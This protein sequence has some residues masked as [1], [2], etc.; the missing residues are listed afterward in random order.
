M[1]PALAD[2]IRG[3]VQMMFT[4]IPESIEYVRAG[5]LR[6]L[7][8]TTTR[9]LEMLEDIPA[10][11]EFLPGFEATS[12]LGVCAPKGTPT[13]IID[14]I[15]GEINAVLADPKIKAQLVTWGLSLASGS[16]ADFGTTIAEETEKWSKVIKF[17]SIKLE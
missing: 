17:A 8:V 14:T 9:R 16:P 7:A 13:A 4:F 3:Q 5:K 1:P 6:A 2:M 10:V 15:N 11:G 12:M